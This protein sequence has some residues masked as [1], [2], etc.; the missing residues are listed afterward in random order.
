MREDIISYAKKKYNTQPEYLWTKAPDIF[1]LRHKKNK[2]WY[3]IVMSIKKNRIILDNNN[4]DLDQ[5]ID[6][7]IDIINIKLEP[8]LI[9]L[10]VDQKNFFRAYHMNKV[11]WIT[12]ILDDTVSDSDIIELID[13][14]YNL[15][16]G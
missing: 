9:D 11:D 5:D 8:S 7:K 3:A 12:I 1:V 6:Q 10:L 4:Y 15:V 16:G 14:S 13:E 2:K